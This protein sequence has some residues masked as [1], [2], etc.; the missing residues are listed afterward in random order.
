MKQALDKDT[1][2]KKSIDTNVVLI[3]DESE[4][5]LLEGCIFYEE[6]EDA[7][8]DQVVKNFEEKKKKSTNGKKKSG[9]R[10]TGKDLADLG[11]RQVMCALNDIVQRL[12]DLE[13][14]VDDGFKAIH[15]AMGVIDSM[16]DK[17]SQL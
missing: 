11:T 8:F 6:V 5:G 1:L 17:V 16:K 4:L 3:E 14:K 15:K 13:N 9:A 10:D 2:S 7:Y 12:I